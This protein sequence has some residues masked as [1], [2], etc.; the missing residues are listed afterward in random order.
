MNLHALCWSDLL[1]MDDQ[2][3]HNMELVDGSSVAV[4]GGGPSGSFFSYFA[5]E[6]AARLDVD[7]NIDIYEPKNFS[8]IGSSG[9]NHCGGIVSES[10][11]QKL[12]TDGIV[13]PAHIIQRGISTYTMHAEQ[14][15]V[16]IKTPSNEHRIA[17]VFRGCGPKGCLDTSQRSF[18]N[19]L[20]GLCQEKGAEIIPEKIT[21]VERLEDGII[22]NSKRFGDKKYDLVVGAVG[23]N[24]K[25]L[26]LFGT[27]NPG[28]R[29]PG[30][31]RTY[32]CEFFLEQDVVDKYFK[33][34]MHVFLLNIPNV[35]FGALIPK[36]NY[37]TMVLLGND[38]DKNV[39][40]D[41]IKSEQVK[42]CFPEDFKLDESAPCKCYP[43]VN[44]KGAVE[45]YSDRMVLVGDSASSKLYKNGI[46]AAYI[47]GR[48]A[49]NTVIF[50]GVSKKDFES[51]YKK[52]CNDLDTDNNVGKLIF[53]VTR[54]IQKSAILKTGLLDMVLREQKETDNKR[55]MSS[56]LWD[57]F[58]GSAGYRN[59]LLRFFHP[60]L[61]LNF[62]WSIVSANF[63]RMKL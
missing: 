39:V 23:L 24:Q 25:T 17:S 59:I 53:W 9:C 21:K 11:V 47:T 7:I 43:F 49:A 52:A 34:S 55:L 5:L 16:V 3:R 42:G 13:I 27:L 28:F 63:K 6:F 8:K 54:I 60:A 62:M 22:V 32:I 36:E 38:I 12:S 10:L 45:P 50:E 26:D 30:V 41:F 56:A 46:G 4:I 35:T 51:S 40:A 2:A 15:E 19:F 20:L 48:A 18:D 1:T 58:T 31:T 14:G 61:L 44:V 33:E 57:T 37:V 29:P